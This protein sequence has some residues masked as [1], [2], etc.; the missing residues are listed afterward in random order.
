MRH[1]VAYHNAEKMGY[2]YKPVGGYSFFSRKALTFL[3]QTVGA[4]VWIINGSRSGA[5]NT[6]YTLCAAYV[7]HEVVDADDVGFDYIVA[8]TVG[9]DFDPP[10]ELNSLPWFSAFLKSQSNFSLGINEIKDTVTIERLATL[11]KDIEIEDLTASG[12]LALPPDF[13]VFGIEVSEGLTT[14]VLHLRRERNRAVI[15]AKKE[16]ALARHGRLLCEVCEFD[17]AAFYGEFGAGYCEVHHTIPLASLNG[18]R[19]TKLADL[20]IVCS[21]CHRILHRNSPMPSI[22]ELKAY[23]SETKT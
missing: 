5:R 1:F 17:F 10:I 21:N 13:D 22:S 16:Q 7:P 6:T 15:D 2:E 18:Q 23:I 14:Y 9:H 4:M 19:V 12:K 20:A 11:A 3:E 8:G